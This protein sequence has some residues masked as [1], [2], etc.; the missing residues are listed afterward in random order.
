MKYL[1]IAVAPIAIALAMV[2]AEESSAAPG[3]ELHIYADGTAHFINAELVTQNALNVFTLNVWGQKWVVPID[4]FAKVES[5]YGAPLELSEFALGHL[6]EVK[7]RPLANKTGWIDPTIVR[8]LSIK[9][10][11]PPPAAASIAAPLLPPPSP[12]APPAAAPAPAPA[13]P[14]A[15]VPAPVPELEAAPPKVSVPKT[16]P[17]PLS[18]ARASRRLTQYLQPGMRGGEVIILQEFLQKNGWGIPDNGPV[19]GYYGKVTVTAVK[20]FQQAKGLPP[21]GVVGPKTRAIIN[22]L[23]EKR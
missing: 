6:L 21:E 11:T 17:P 23:L 2:G 20:N 14:I 9:T 3:Q 8:N 13:P 18:Q 10:G 22:T 19:T 5:A 12:L 16:A 15:V 7:G 1:A 4:R